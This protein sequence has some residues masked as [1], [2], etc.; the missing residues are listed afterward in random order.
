MRTGIIT[1]L[2]LSLC[3]TGCLY[4][5]RVN[6]QI[7]E[8]ELRLEEDCIYRLKW[9]LEDCQQQLAAAKFQAETLQ[10]EADVLRGRNAAGV[11]D[12]GTPGPSGG[13]RQ[14]SSPN[15][16]PAPRLP[17]VEGVEP[18]SGGGASTERQSPSIL[19]KLEEMASPVKLVAHQESV[20]PAADRL[21][22][23]ANVERIVLNP[24][25]TGGVARGGK[26]GDQAL[27]V[28]IEQR[29]S[30][31]ARVLAPGDV[32]IV[33]VDPKLQGEA[34]RVG[35]WTFDADEAQHHVR[36]NGE[37]GSFHFELPW[38][39]T[40]EHSD[41]RLFVRFTTYDGRRLEANLPIEVQLADTQGGW[42]KSTSPP[43]E[44]PVDSATESLRADKTAA[45][46]SSDDQAP[47]TARKSRE[48]APTR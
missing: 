48:W 17:S 42:K 47:K 32:S 15:L 41:L 26:S 9:Q 12:Y 8:R 30:R 11:P 40:P 16:P 7:M 38:Q 21:N 35:K 19:A 29:D 14:D 18:P 43:P 22:P 5:N 39:K 31:G 44:K 1:I 34:A 2:L 45:D 23:D 20:S 3:S 25:L 27:N 13:G 46:D 4:R 28:V 37:G 33:V 6:Q 36:R 10:K 24:G